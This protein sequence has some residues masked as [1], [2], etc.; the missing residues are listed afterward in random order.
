[1]KIKPIHPKKPNVYCGPCK[2]CSRPV[3]SA[4]GFADLD[5]KPFEYFCHECGE[6]TK[7]EGNSVME[8]LKSYSHVQCPKCKW[9]GDYGEMLEHGENV[10][11]CPYCGE[12]IANEDLIRL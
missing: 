9:A 1:M 7:H 8:E 3:W 6:L 11:E 10:S 12:D 2:V 5:G 4:D